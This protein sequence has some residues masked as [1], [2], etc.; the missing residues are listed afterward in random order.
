MRKAIWA[1]LV[2]GMA[3]G[4]PAWAQSQTAFS[5]QPR[6]L[7]FKPTSTTKNLAAPVPAQ[8]SSGFSLTRFIPKLTLPSFSAHPTIGQSP[9]PPAGAFPSTHFNSPF[10]PQKPFTPKK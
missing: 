8:Q 5:N 1:A 4:S 3:L 7:T 9:L 2:V 10:Q 6:R